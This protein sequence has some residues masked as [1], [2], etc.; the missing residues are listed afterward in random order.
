[1]P[2]Y[3]LPDY[4]N[5]TE[6]LTMAAAAPD[7]VIRPLYEQAVAAGFP[8]PAEGY[9]EQGLDLNQYLGAI[10]RRPSSSGCAAIRWSMRASTAAT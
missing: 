8:S 4:P 7:I 9:A 10:R 5:V 6:P 3:P 2:A 1:M